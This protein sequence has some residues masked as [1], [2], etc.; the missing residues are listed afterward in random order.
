MDVTNQI[1]RPA[2]DVIIFGTGVYAEVAYVYLTKD[3][4]HN[5]VAFTVH[6]QYRKSDTLLGLDIVPFEELRK[7]YP[8]EQYAMLIA[9]GFSGVNKTRENLY[10]L[11]K[12]QG[13]ELITYINSKAMHWGE[14]EVGDN[15][16]ILEANVIQPFVKIGNNVTL[17]S[18]NHIG[19]HASIG[20]HCFVASHAVISGQVKIGDY[21]FVGVNTTFRDGVK[22]GQSCVIGAGAMVMQDTQDKDVLAV[23]ST[24]PSRVKSDQLRGF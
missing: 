18:G 6:E 13:Y 5:V 3:S 8:P 19:H 17:W 22:V 12:S 21:T 24:P 16:F 23:K 9:V 20:N 2:R 1:D 10:N 15:C 7:T 11:C 4:P 14:F